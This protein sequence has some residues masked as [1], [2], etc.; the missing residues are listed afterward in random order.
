[1]IH[2]QQLVYAVSLCSQIRTFNNPYIRE[3]FWVPV[4]QTPETSLRSLSLS[5]MYSIKDLKVHCDRAVHLGEVWRFYS[6]TECKQ[7]RERWL[8]RLHERTP[9]APDLR[10]LACSQTPPSTFKEDLRERTQSPSESFSA[11]NIAGSRCT[12]AVLLVSY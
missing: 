2:R 10:T 7:Q 1:M 5:V 9:R 6:G 3:T 8:K 4:S 11:E 12:T